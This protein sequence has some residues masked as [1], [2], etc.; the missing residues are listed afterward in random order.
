EAA[1]KG[2]TEAGMAFYADDV[3][4]MPSYMK[5]IKGVEAM[6][7]FDAEREGKEPDITDMKLNTLEVIK[8][9]NM[10]IE[11][12]TYSLSF[13][14]PQTSETINDY[15]KYVTIWEKTDDSMKIKVEIWNTDM[16]PWA[17]TQEKPQEKPQEKDGGVEKKN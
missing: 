14:M 9:G 17:M 7:K 6:R 12:G 10:I 8:S 2:D 4:Y 3:Y 1:I 13:I 11:I 15:G 5:M 16:N